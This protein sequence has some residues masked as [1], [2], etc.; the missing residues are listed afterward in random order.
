MNDIKIQNET[1]NETLTCGHPPTPDKYTTGY[2]TSPNGEKMCF[3]CAEKAELRD[4]LNAT[5]Y[6]GYVNE[7][8]KLITTWT[9]GELAKITGITRGN[10][11]WSLNGMWRM[12]YVYA[13][14]SSGRH[15]YGY[16]SDSYE[17]VTLRV[18]K[19]E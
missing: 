1:T 16:S 7:D 2:A 19:G 15:W 12:R 13:V 3:P 6:T 14:D 8:K 4:F 18:L 11:H 17:V 9:G 5:R 10:K